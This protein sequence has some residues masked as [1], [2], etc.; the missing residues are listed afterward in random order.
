MIPKKMKA[1]VAP[2]YGK[3]LEI[4]EVDVREPGR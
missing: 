4:R 3:P 1:A 2:G